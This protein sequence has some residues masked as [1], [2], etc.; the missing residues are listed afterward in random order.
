[1]TEYKAFDHTNNTWY[2]PENSKPVYVGNCTTVDWEELIRIVEPQTGFISPDT[3]L[4]NHKLD[5]L[6]EQLQDLIS[7]YN[8][9]GA[10]WITYPNDDFYDDKFNKEFG[11]FIN[12]PNYHRAWVSRVNPG[13]TVPYHWDID[14]NI[15]NYIKKGPVE[16]YICVMTKPT[17]GCCAVIGDTPLYDCNVG[18]VFMWKDFN[19][20]HGS[21]NASTK[22]KYQYNYITYE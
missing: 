16:R 6:F 21:V 8:L 13:K 17:L 9:N 15:P 2:V 18:D 4:K 3:A 22:T 7:R 1:M 19:M 20:W 12:R 11:K 10:E 14:F 5:P